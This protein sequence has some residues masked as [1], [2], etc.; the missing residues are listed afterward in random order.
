MEGANST[1]EVIESLQFVG[2]HLTG[3]GNPSDEM[4]QKDRKNIQSILDAMPPK[5]ETFRDSSEIETVLEVNKFI[6]QCVR[7]WSL[8]VITQNNC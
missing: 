2:T 7:Q 6:L 8:L 3:Y 4:I 5:M 1:R